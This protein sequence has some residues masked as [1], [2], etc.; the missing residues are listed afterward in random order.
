M[1]RL[2]ER[3]IAWFFNATTVA[4]AVV[5]QGAEA[6]GHRGSFWEAVAK[7]TQ[8]GLFALLPQVVDAVHIPVIAAVGRRIRYPPC[9]KNQRRMPYR[10]M[11]S[12]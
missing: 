6:G 7:H 9:P 8:I 12:K 4:D 5:A 11:G 3:G 10:R 2:K 1:A